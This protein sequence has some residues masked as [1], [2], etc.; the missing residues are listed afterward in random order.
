MEENEQTSPKKTE[1]REEDEDLR[2]LL[3]PQMGR[4]MTITKDDIKQR[5]RLIKVKLSEEINQDEG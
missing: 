5:E 1:I 3:Q 4:V 2:E